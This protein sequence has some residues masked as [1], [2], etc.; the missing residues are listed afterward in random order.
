MEFRDYYDNVVLRV[1]DN[2][3]YNTNGTWVYVKNGDYICNTAG[4]WE[5]VIRGT[6]VYDARDNWVFNVHQ[7][8]I[9]DIPGPEPTDWHP[10]T[11]PRYG[12]E[13]VYTRHDAGSNSGQKPGKLRIPLIVAASI[14]VLLVVG[15]GVLFFSGRL[16]GGAVKASTP[17]ITG[18]NT[19]V[20]VITPPPSAEDY[21]Y[22]GSSA[23][24]NEDADQG[25]A[26]YVEYGLLIRIA[27]GDLTPA[28]AEYYLHT[29]ADNL[30]PELEYYLRIIA[31]Y[32]NDQDNHISEN[33]GQAQE[34]PVYEG[35][36]SA[37]S[38]EQ[39][40]QH[41]ESNTNSNQIRVVINDGQMAFLPHNEEIAELFVENMEL[42]QLIN[43][44]SFPHDNISLLELANAINRLYNEQ[45]ADFVIT[46]LRATRDDLEYIAREIREEVQNQTV[47]VTL[48]N[49]L[50]VELPNHQEIVDLF[51]REIDMRIALY[52]N[53]PRFLINFPIDDA[54][55][56][57]WSSTMTSEFIA[58]GP[59]R[60]IFWINE[61]INAI[62]DIKNV[63]VSERFVP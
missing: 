40:N 41:T 42:R 4:N 3:C 14:A 51:I 25:L 11:Q 20:P 56:Q 38:Q 10:S 60:P 50:Q 9:Y 19:T 48:G 44:P 55:V 52:A 62:R 33:S 16:G 26:E 12:R 54:A 5:Y 32:H 30:T 59:A 18:G 13:P 1:V 17:S 37:T 35:Y 2:K 58:S 7:S 45:G 15:M 23:D 61:S 53:D 24:T 47:H 28:Q 29:L 46:W 39:S 21:Y 22:A 27:A 49:G 57:F 43:S 8:H 36:T 63:P 31:G 34:W 6:R